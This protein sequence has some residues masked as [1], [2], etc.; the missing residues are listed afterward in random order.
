MTRTTVYRY[1]PS[2]ESLLIELLLTVSEDRTRRPR[3]A[4][5]VETGQGHDTHRA[6]VLEI[7]H[8]LNRYV[9]ENEVMQRTALRHYL[10][11]LARGRGTAGEGHDRAA[12][13]G[14]ASA[15]D[16]CRHRAAGRHRSRR[17]A[18]VG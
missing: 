17:R 15:V 6:G 4:A 10:D 2:Q 8:R 12:P 3:G 18:C 7:V 9:A 5:R 1:F 16:R 11:T 13:R 14:T